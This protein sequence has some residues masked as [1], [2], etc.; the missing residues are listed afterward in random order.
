MLIFYIGFTALIESIR[1]IINPEE[2]NYQTATVVVVSVA[3]VVKIILGLYV[4]HAG[5]KLKSGSLVGSGV[6]ALYDAIISAATLVAIIVFFAFGWQ[7]EAYLAAGISL[8][9]L[10]SG[11][12]IIREAF[13]MIL[14]KRVDP[15]ISRR[16]KMEIAKIDG[17]K[18][19]PEFIA[20]DYGNGVMH[21]S[22]N[23]EVD[24]VMKASEI[25]AISREIRSTV[26][27]KYQIVINSV[28]IQT[29]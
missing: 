1:K 29:N 16:V 5:K 3:I 26:F 20:H 10:R 27:E 22:V 28:G 11:V 8:F 18:S 24:G 12:K 15:A 17:V 25:D 23:I 14:G 19:V 4:R 2:V 21:A 6:D 9:I 13:S 7:I